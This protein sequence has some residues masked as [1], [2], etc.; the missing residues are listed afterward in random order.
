MLV[1]LREN[2]RISEEE[3]ARSLLPFATGGKLSFFGQRR[4]RKALPN[5]IFTVVRRERRESAL[6]LPRHANGERRRR[7]LEP[8]AC[9]FIFFGSQRRTWSS[10]SS[11]AA[12]KKNGKRESWEKKLGNPLRVFHPSQTNK[13][14][15]LNLS[16]FSK[17]ETRKK[18]KRGHKINAIAHGSF[19]PYLVRKRGKGR[20]TR[21]AS[22]RG[23]GSTMITCKLS[24]LAGEGGKAKC[25]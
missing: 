25:F 15:Q 16:T 20:L 23:K 13:R 1:D 5:V 6:L 18:G 2:A 8:Q 14:C 9:L 3:V 11:H 12:R 17:G 10:V 24:F 4:G 21:S 19:L 22:R 7:A